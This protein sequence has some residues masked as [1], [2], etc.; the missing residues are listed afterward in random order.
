MVNY[1]KTMRKELD[2]KA[3]TLIELI[4]VM[5][6]LAVLVLLAAPQFLGY[7]NKAKVANIQN[8]IA[9][10]ELKTSENLIDY[11]WEEK[12]FD[13]WP[14]AGDETYLKEIA[15]DETGGG[16]YG[17]GGKLDPY[18]KDNPADL[19]K[20]IPEGEY[21]IIPSAFLEKDVRTQLD[22]TFFANDNGDVFYTSESI[23]TIDD[24][25]GNGDGNLDDESGDGGENQNPDGSGNE[26]ED[27]SD[28]SDNEQDTPKDYTEREEVDYG[29]YEELGVDGVAWVNKMIDQGYEMGSLDVFSWYAEFEDEDGFTYW[30]YNTD[31][32]ANETGYWKYVSFQPKVIIPLRLDGQLL[33]SYENMFSQKS[34]DSVASNNPYVTNMAWM[35]QGSRSLWTDKLDLSNFDTSNVTNMEGMFTMSTFDTV[36]VSTQEIVD[37]LRTKSGIPEDTDFTVINN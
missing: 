14:T 37:I 27:P 10:A 28:G 15:G 25:S 36:V 11:Q 33:T 20:E 24:E 6:I 35:F 3:F 23:E 26:V 9:V 29:G 12:V 17:K 31:D 13:S 8:D 18:D 21:K 19:D 22:G 2:D 5:A 34:V 1:V 16:L 30:A 32:Y 7:T 4:V